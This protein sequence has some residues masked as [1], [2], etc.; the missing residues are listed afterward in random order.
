MN[1]AS[2]T[3]TNSRVRIVQGLVAA[4][5][6]LLTVVDAQAGNCHLS[7]EAN[8]L[9]Q[10]NARALQIDPD[11]KD[12]QLTLKHVGKQP[13]HV[14]GHDWVLSRSSDVAALANAGIAAGL[15]HGYVPQGDARIIASTKVVGGGEETTVTFS[16]GSLVPGVDYSYFCS[17]PGHSTFMRGR[18]MLAD[19]TKLAVNR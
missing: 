4:S 18:L 19:R 2:G 8:D 5:L 12:I 13:A 7:I 1:H 15:E 10:Y 3:V 16:A 9:M 17:Y 6:L 14:L 11:C